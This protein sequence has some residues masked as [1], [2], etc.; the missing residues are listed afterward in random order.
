MEIKKELYKRIESG[1]LAYKSMDDIYAA[2][3]IKPHE[4][5]RVIFALE[6]LISEGKVIE[7]QNRTF[8]TL[9]KGNTFTGTM[10][11][12]PKGYGFIIRDDG[13]PDMMVPKRFMNGAYD[14]DKVVAIPLKD[15][16]DEAYV[17][18]VKEHA[19]KRVVG[20]AYRTQGKLIV[21]PDNPRYPEIFIPNRQAL[22]ARDGDKVVAYITEFTP[23]KNPAGTITEILGQSLYFDTEELATIKAY[24]LETEFPEE[25]TAEAEQVSAGEIVPFKREDFR[26]QLIFTI[27]GE[28]T[29]D[30]DD[31]VSLEKDGDNYILG[32]HI[33][34]VSHYVTMGSA[35]D[36]EAYSRGTSVYFPDRV[37]PMLPT[38]LSNGSCSLNENEDRYT[39]SCVMTFDA[40]ANKLSS[41]ICEG[42]ICS[43]HK[44]TYPEITTLLD[45]DTSKYPDLAETVQLMKE[46]CLKM[47][48]K[49]AR[50][51]KIDL[52]IDEPHIYMDE[53]GDIQIPPVEKGELTLSHRIIEEFMIAANESVAEYLTKRQAPC[54]YRVH[55]KPDE[56]KVT[57]FIDF[58]EGIGVRIRMHAEDVTPL[59]FCRLL[60]QT[61]DMPQYATINKIMLRTMQKAR[62]CEENLGHFGL[63]SPMYC[64]F[65]SP[66]RRYPDLFVHRSVKALLHGDKKTTEKLRRDAHDAGTDC[67][68]KERNAD[69]A[70][71]AVDTLYKVA[72]MQDKTG[73]QY[74]AVVSGV[75]KS[76]VFCELNNTVE[77]FIPIET[78]DGEYEYIAEKFTLSGRLKSYTIGQ[79]IRIEVVDTDAITRKIYFKE[80]TE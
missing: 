79:K 42:I 4:R 59:D 40:Q 7:L 77:G 65:T 5:R 30:M 38:A 39:L 26:G 12:S 75:A 53:N 24:N 48:T 17:V 67:S 21:R 47:E 20:N 22:R 34:D 62:Y 32:V 64:H 46:L 61:K 11:A 43:R 50:E 70:E 72:Y 3:Q 2:L 15:G 68:A 60:D 37:L 52:D 8:C 31:A 36:K 69:E 49:R 56:E 41:H 1:E 25:V 55:E 35:L 58:V 14:G 51:G 23:G 44:T 10:Q 13:G 29:R 28:D 63:A 71:R 45:G 27:D 78:L 80:V 16:G 9:D 66:I 19:L 74:D 54:L 33:A 76:G 18:Q 73:M 57:N 6:E